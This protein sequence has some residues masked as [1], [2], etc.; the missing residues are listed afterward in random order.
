MV[1]PKCHASVADDSNF[2]P[3]CG[4]PFGKRDGFV[5]TLWRDNKPGFQV[6]SLLL[7]AMLGS[8]GYYLSSRT[9]TFV[10]TVESIAADEALDIVTRATFKEYCQQFPRDCQNRSS[11]ELQTAIKSV[12]PRLLNPL[13]P[14]QGYA[15]ITYKN[16]TGEPITVTQFK[17]RRPPGSWS[18]A[19][20]QSVFGSRIQILRSAILLRGTNASFEEKVELALMSATTANHSTFSLAPGEEKV[21][22]LSNV[23]QNAEFQVDFTRAGASYSTAI[24]RL[25]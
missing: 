4:T 16:A 18:T 13:K 22:R 2:C 14:G 23:N 11:T 17:Y 25:R 7:V 19:N 10:V 8:F 1:C 20:S 5:A 9:R 21:W 12:L 24:L 15:K 3:R 6:L